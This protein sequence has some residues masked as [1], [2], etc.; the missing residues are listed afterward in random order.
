MGAGALLMGVEQ[1]R[2][3][4]TTPK[5]G[6]E[7]RRFTASNKRVRAIMGPQGSGKTYECLKEFLR[8]AV[9]QA[10]STLDGVRRTRWVAIRDTYRNLEK[11]TIASWLNI[12]PKSMGTFTGGGGGEPA[13]HVIRW[14]QKGVGP[15]E[16]TVEFV[17]IGDQ[18]VEDV[19]RGLEVTGAY[20]NEADLLAREVFNFL[21][22]RIGRYPSAAHGGATWFGIWM[23]FN[24]PDTDNWA[25]D[26]FVEN[27]PEEFEFF[28]QPGGRSPHAENI[29][30]L[31]VGYYQS[32][33]EGQPDWWVRRMVDNRFGFS[34]EGQP[35]YPEFNDALHISA[36]PLLPIKGRVI[37]I[38]LD[39]GKTPAALLSQTDAEGQYRALNE[40][41]GVNIG[42]RAFG[43]RLSAFLA[44]TYPH[45][46]VVGIADPSAAYATDTSEQS[47]IDI[48]A[49]T[50]QMDV[51]PAPTNDPLLRQEAVRQPLLRMISADKPAAIY[52]PECKVLRRGF[53][54]G[55]RYRKIRIGGSERF[56]DRPEKNEFS[57][58][59]DA[60]QYAALDATDFA[61]LMG[62]GE[63]RGRTRE[64]LDYD[65]LG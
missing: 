44:Q 10:P 15:V 22:G 26:L 5:S 7:L 29:E 51:I 62:R 16:V 12:V 52:S 21:R 24:A 28:R 18:N 20:I 47:W 64:E 45:F 43:E 39:A 36:Q 54:S 25:Y 41:V 33:I 56:D 2:L 55:Y 58:I 11:T 50:V 19:L 40:F 34:R 46:D 31:P 14:D 17:A 35:V 38:G 57:H 9:R 8:R 13:K 53:N 3:D 48:V 59:H 60:N 42:A 30:N 63:G 1:I 23:D 32:Q 4:L 49:A 6:V 65:P 37:K 61:A 27:R